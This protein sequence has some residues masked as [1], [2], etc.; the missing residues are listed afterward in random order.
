M[1]RAGSTINRSERPMHPTALFRHCPRCG[2]GLASA[3]AN[4]LTC[5]GCGFTYF[6]N[7]TVAAA[8][9]LF[10]GVGRALFIRRANEPSRGKLA[11]P[12]GFIDIG[13]TAEAG[14]RREV[15]EEVGLEIDR[16]AFLGSCPNDYLYRGVTY[17]VVDLIF[18]ADAVNPHAAQALDAVAGLEWKPVADV[19]PAEL[20]FPSLRM[21]WEKLTGR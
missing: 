15:R 1:R 7:P 21:G 6:F 19:D 17:P 2:A 8:A 16:L 9:Y 4:P 18:T 14:L 11:I 5:A 12:G 3:A 10:D 20:A 13:E